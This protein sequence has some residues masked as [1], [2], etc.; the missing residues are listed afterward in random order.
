[1]WLCLAAPD[2]YSRPRSWPADGGEAVL[3]SGLVKM[4][5]MWVRSVFRHKELPG[6]RGTGEDTV[7]KAQ[8]LELSVGIGFMPFSPLGK[9]FLTGAVTA[10]GR[11]HDE[12][13]EH[14][15]EAPEVLLG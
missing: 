14:A 7:E 6:D 4:R 1:M 15:L 11:L 12:A 5:L 8:D 13:V 9:G 2:C 10:G 3:T